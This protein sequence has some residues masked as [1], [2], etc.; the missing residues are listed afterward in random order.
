M[1]DHPIRLRRSLANT[2]A[3]RLLESHAQGIEVGLDDLPDDPLTERE[4]RAAGADRRLGV[5]APD[6]FT[7]M[8]KRGASPEEVLGRLRDGITQIRDLREAQRIINE[9]GRLPSAGRLLRRVVTQE[10]LNR[11][12]QERRHG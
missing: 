2:R 9:I 11:L 1:A 8:L 10:V 6:W 7:D 3:R 5:K 12:Q 4:E